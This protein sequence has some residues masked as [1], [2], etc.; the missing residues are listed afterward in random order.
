MTFGKT[1]QR[2]RRAKDMTQRDVANDIPMDYSYYSKLENDRFD[3]NPTRETIYKIAKALKC[4]D[5]EKNDLLAAAGRNMQEMEQVT[6]VANAN[7]E[8]RKPLSKLFKAAINLSPERLD[9]LAADV[10]EE[11]QKIKSNLEVK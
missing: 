4:T 5:E 9:K 10:E 8:M 6:R 1:L 3:S 7:P 11:S 2:I